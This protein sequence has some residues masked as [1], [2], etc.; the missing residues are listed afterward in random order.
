[1]I[2]NGET[3]RNYFISSPEFYLIVWL[4]AFPKNF[5]KIAI[6]K[7]LELFSFFSVKTN[8]GEKKA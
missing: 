6:L 2:L 1:M 5:E 8:F 7:I 3:F 4:M